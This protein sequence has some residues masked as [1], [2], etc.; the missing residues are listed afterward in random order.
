MF[1]CCLQ[2]LQLQ[3]TLGTPYCFVDKFAYLAFMFAV[4]I[5]KDRHLWL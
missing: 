4:Q 1:D 2:S 3:A 5:D